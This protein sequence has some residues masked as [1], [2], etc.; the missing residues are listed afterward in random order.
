MCGIEQMTDSS[1]DPM[2]GR[3]QKEGNLMYIGSGLLGLIL[4][5]ALVVFF[6]RRV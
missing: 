4:I 2:R 1:C 6:M 5:V 3:N